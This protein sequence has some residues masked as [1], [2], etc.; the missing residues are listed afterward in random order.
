V[1]A[2]HPALLL[3]YVTLID[4][5]GLTGHQ[6]GLEIL[7]DALDRAAAVLF[8]VDVLPLP[9]PDLNLISEARNV[10][11]C[12]VFSVADLPG[13][14]PGE[15]RLRDVLAEHAPSFAE[16]RCVSRADV[17]GLRDVLVAVA[18]SAHL[19][20][21]SQPL[22]QVRGAAVE[23]LDTLRARLAAARRDDAVLARI[24]H[25][26]A[27]ATGRDA[28]AAP[29]PTPAWSSAPS[30]PAARL[31]T[32]IDAI[33]R[34]LDDRCQDA[35]LA[36]L[37]RL[38]Q[39]LDV[40]LAALAVACSRSL[41]FWTGHAAR[42]AL[43][44]IATTE[45]RSLELWFTARVF[46]LCNR[47]EV[48]AHDR[49]L[50]AIDAPKPRPTWHTGPFPLGGRPTLP[51]AGF[52][53]RLSDDAYDA[54]HR[55]VAVGDPQVR[56]QRARRWLQ[57]VLDAASVSVSA[58]VEHRTARLDTALAQALAEEH[59]RRSRR[60]DRQLADLHAARADPAVS[61]RLTATLAEEHA[62]VIDWIRRIDAVLIRV[63]DAVQG[64]DAQA[65]E[66]AEE[67]RPPR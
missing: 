45:P 7:L 6:P 59:H 21:A 33:R 67:L 17:T 50:V 40:A 16:A 19:R 34:L 66:A 10:T 57:Q 39:D 32:R 9:E 36:A 1:V 31:G 53:V 18:G 51:V 30:A 24:S 54:W 43:R 61:D 46:H 28:T 14:R 62:T 41:A 2:Q 60:L 56:S 12:M 13:P 55:L 47:G 4:T 48:R 29:R 5:P 37:A 63:R 44:D 27:A 52:D 26:R 11:D 23:E 38:P 20:R 15:A 49:S 64:Q 58:E 22:R 3:E 35:D 65:A 42:F 8:V 25:Q